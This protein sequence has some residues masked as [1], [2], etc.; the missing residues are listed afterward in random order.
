MGFDVGDMGTAYG[1]YQ[2]DLTGAYSDRYGQGYIHSLN[3]YLIEGANFPTRDVVDGDHQSAHCDFYQPYDIGHFRFG[4]AEFRL[5][6][7]GRFV[8][9]GVS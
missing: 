6:S 7:G 8:F 1:G 9:L 4:I 5:E 3:T 2:S